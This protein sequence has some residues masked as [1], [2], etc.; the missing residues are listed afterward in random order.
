[1]TNIIQYLFTILGAGLAILAFLTGLGDW[2]TDFVLVQVPAFI[3]AALPVE[4]TDALTV[5]TIDD[6]AYTIAEVNWFIPFF[7]LIGIY[8]TGVGAAFSLL[9]LRYIFGYF[10]GG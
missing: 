3:W 6:I 4:T 5:E 10:V 7:A 8:L 2:I 1:M 9:L